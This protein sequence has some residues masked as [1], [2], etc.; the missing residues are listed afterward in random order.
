MVDLGCTAGPEYGSTRAGCT[1]AWACAADTAPALCA[2]LPHVRDWMRRILK[3]LSVLQAYVPPV[4]L[5]TTVAALGF[6]A[7]QASRGL[8]TLPAGPEL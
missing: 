1:R 5:P 4:A 7:K 6:I 3:S 2:A 8:G